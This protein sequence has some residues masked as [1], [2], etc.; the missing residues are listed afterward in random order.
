M[1]SK[2]CVNFNVIST[3]SSVRLLLSG[4]MFILV[5]LILSSC[6]DSD[7]KR[8]GMFGFFV[9]KDRNYIYERNS[10]SYGVV[11]S[12]HSLLRYL[13]GYEVM[14]PVDVNF[15]YGDYLGMVASNL[16]M[17]FY[18]TGEYRLEDEMV[19]Y[20]VNVHEKRG[21]V[22]W[23]GELSGG[24]DADELFNLADEMAVMVANVI[25]GREMGMGSIG[26][27]VVG[28]GIKEIDIVLNN[29]AVYTKVKDGF[30]SKLNVISGIEYTIDVVDS[31]DGSILASGNVLVE[32][33]RERDI[34]ID[35]RVV[36]D[37]KI[38]KILGADVTGRRLRFEVWTG[39]LGMLSVGARYVLNDSF[40]V[41]LGIGD[42]F[43]INEATGKI[44]NKVSACFGGRYVVWNTDWGEFGIV[45]DLYG[46]YYGGGIRDV[47]LGFGLN[48][49]VW[50]FSL[51]LGLGVGM[52]AFRDF[53]YGMYWGFGLRF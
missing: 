47:G 37:R 46:S 33:E 11:K 51:D 30:K 8:V 39:S 35:I 3:F 16:G 27:E 32:K 18:V 26:F 19:I 7:V 52:I 10:Y 53:S 12:S 6:G 42:S 21:M 5:G 9:Q 25:V 1:L 34:V 29:Q 13:R 50:M 2:K 23:T 49:S 4:F 14:E 22:M 38:V 43:L 36:G 15:R 41:R 24:T 40:S 48:Y 20:K 45:S 44:Y 31:S 28:G 17:D